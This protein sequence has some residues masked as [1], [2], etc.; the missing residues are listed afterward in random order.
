[1]SLR[2]VSPAVVEHVTGTWVKQ[3]RNRPEENDQRLWSCPTYPFQI[4][5]VEQV[6]PTR[7]ALEAFEARRNELDRKLGPHNKLETVQAFYCPSSQEVLNNIVKEGFHGTFSGELTF[8]LDAPQ[9]IQETLSNSRANKVLLVRVTLGVKDVDYT[10]INHKYKLRNLRSVIP[11][12]VITYQEIGES[13]IPVPQSPPPDSN[14]VELTLNANQ[15][16]HLAKSQ[17]SPQLVSPPPHQST[18]TASTSSAR[19]PKYLKDL[20]ESLGD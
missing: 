18:S 1:M 20:D 15:L 12:F 17:S 16:N 2:L 7:S 14:V 5:S 10:E 8:C 13:R 3:L 6:S 9:A 11:S 19:L 4:V